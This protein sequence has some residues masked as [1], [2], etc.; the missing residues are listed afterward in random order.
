[1][2]ADLGNDEKIELAERGAHRVGARQADGGIG[3]MIHSASIAPRSSPRTASPP[4][5]P[6]PSPSPARSRIAARD[7]RQRMEVHARGELVGETADLATAHRIGWPVSENGPNP[8]CR[9]ARSPDERR[10]SR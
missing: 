6:A 3:A 4:S 1:M 2:G 9:C 7:R 5:D 8:A 10:R